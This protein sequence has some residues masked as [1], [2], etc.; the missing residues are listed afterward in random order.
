MEHLLFCDVGALWNVKSCKAGIYDFS[1][2]L[3]GSFSLQSRCIMDLRIAADVMA[4]NAGAV[5]DI[6]LDAVS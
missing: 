4:V 6:P 1:Q 2:Q 5:L 3:F